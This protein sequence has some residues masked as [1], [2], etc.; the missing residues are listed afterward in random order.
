VQG[1]WEDEKERHDQTGKMLYALGLRF[2]EPITDYERNP[3]VV[4]NI[5]VYRKAQYLVLDDE[6]HNGYDSW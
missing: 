1:W 4:L 2:R 5:K 6:S 3:F